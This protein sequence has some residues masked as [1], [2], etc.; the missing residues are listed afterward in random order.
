MVIKLNSTSGGASSIGYGLTKKRDI[1]QADNILAKQNENVLFVRA[2]HLKVNRI[3]SGISR[4]ALRK[5]TGKPCLVLNW[6][7]GS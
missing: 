6:C 4:Y 7:R 2:D 5:R 1:K 3:N